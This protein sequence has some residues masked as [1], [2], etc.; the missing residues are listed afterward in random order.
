[1]IPDILQYFLDDFWNFQNFQQIW[2]RGPRIYH[3]NGHKN[4]RKLWEHLGKILS[5]H[6]WTF[7]KSKKSQICDIT[8]HHFLGKHIFWF[9]EFVVQKPFEFR[10]FCIKTQNYGGGISVNLE[11]L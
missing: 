6:I 5:F 11:Y 4:I 10:A 7:W 2:T 8:V 9:S 3:Q 1:M